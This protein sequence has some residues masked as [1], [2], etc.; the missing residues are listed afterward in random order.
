MAKKKEKKLVELQN[1]IAK[2][3]ENIDQAMNERMEEATKR[4]KA[5]ADER[6]RLIDEEKNAAV[7]RLSDIQSKLEVDR[8]QLEVTK[9]ELFDVSQTATEKVEAKSA[10][11]EYLNNVISTTYYWRLIQTFI[12]NKIYSFQVELLLEDLE[13]ANQKAD[14]FEKE[15]EQA[16]DQLKDVQ[17]RE[18]QADTST[19]NE[20]YE[21]T[22]EESD[23][24]IASKE[25]EIQRLVKKVDKLSNE[26]ET[27]EY[28]LA[29]RI[30]TL[31]TQNKEYGKEIS[32][33]QNKLQKQNDYDSIKRDLA[34]LR[35]LEGDNNADEIGAEDGENKKP[36]EVLILERSKALQAENT[37]LRMDKERLGS[38][39]DKTNNDLL[40]KCSEYEKQ[41]VLIKELEMHVERLQQITTSSHRGEA[42][43]GRSSTDIL[44][45]LDTLSGSGGQN[46]K[47]SSVFLVDENEMHDLSAQTTPSITDKEQEHVQQASYLL[48][49]IQVKHK[50]DARKGY[51]NMILTFTMQF[52]S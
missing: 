4:I 5:E 40:S 17:S 42:D 22:L 41:S 34:I 23:K 2:Y 28:S 32:L 3:D 33:L 7:Q 49:I 10:E 13:K 29:A 8:R 52:A 30:D 43:G 31:D 18:N 19:T 50:H 6:V 47:N 46:S 37:S 14:L 12:T 15:L 24:K 35:S 36:V 38:A 45:E 20:D 11:G 44:K 1:L 21:Q 16:K 26:M 9:S 25:Y 48:P 51:F 39:L 27:K